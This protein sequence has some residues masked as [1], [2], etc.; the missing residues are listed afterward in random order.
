MSRSLIVTHEGFDMPFLNFTALDTEGH[1]VR[2]IYVVDQHNHTSW[3][4][5]P[6]E[7]EEKDEW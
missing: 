5:L 4:F 6:P 7:E 1:V 2:D 3:S